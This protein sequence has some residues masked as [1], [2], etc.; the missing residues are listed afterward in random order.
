MG[1]EGRAREAV[2]FIPE[3]DSWKINTF[4][5][6]KR[7]AM[8]HPLGFIVGKAGHKTILQQD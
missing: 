3:S 2:S 4:K 1:G 7:L 6:L 8:H 5:P